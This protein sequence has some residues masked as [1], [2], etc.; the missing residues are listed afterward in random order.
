MDGREH[1]DKM[2]ERM[3]GLCRKS[4]RENYR[5]QKGQEASAAG[6]I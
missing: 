6:R 5:E 3:G 1:V 4:G 2:M